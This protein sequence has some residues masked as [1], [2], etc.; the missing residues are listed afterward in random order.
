VTLRSGLASRSAAATGDC[1]ILDVQMP[2]VSGLEVLDELRRRG[3]RLPSIV[4][5]DQ[6]DGT[7]QQTAAE[8][9]TVIRTL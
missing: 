5:T 8:H 6:A 3:Y 1:L 2:G 9:P 4:V 7:T